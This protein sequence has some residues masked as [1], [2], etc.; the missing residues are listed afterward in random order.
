[1]WGEPPAGGAV[2]RGLVEVL[3][4]RVY[5]SCLMLKA[6]AL[7]MLLIMFFG[8]RYLH[9]FICGDGCGQTVEK[10]CCG[11]LCL[12]KQVKQLG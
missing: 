7:E 10:V 9:L 12:F 3:S 4:S 11:Q 5:R 2:W 1:M 8:H 6:A